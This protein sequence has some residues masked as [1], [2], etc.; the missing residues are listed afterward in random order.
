MLRGTLRRVPALAAVL[1]H[2]LFGASSAADDE[3]PRAAEPTPPR[4]PDAAAP[5]GTA[6]DERRE[7]EA[8]ETGF[9]KLPALAPPSALGGLL[10][11][12]IVRIEI[13]PVGGRWEEQPK[14]RF[15]RP[16]DSLTSEVARRAMLELT[17]TGRFANV[18]AEAES[19][20]QGV[21]LRIKVV[22]R[23]IVASVRVSGGVL[24][25]EDTLRTARVRAGSEVTAAELAAIARRVESHYARRGL[26]SA[27]VRI[28]AVDTDDPMRVVVLLDVIPGEP[29]RIAQRR[30]LIW[31]SPKVDGLK[32]ALSHYPVPEKARADEEELA[33]ADRVLEATMRM[34]GWHRAVV[35]HEL[36]VVGGATVLV[37]DI[38]AGPLVRLKFEGIR[39][40]DSSQIERTLELED[41]D[42]RSPST[43]A[44]RIRKFYVDRGFLD[45]EVSFRERGAESAPIHDLVF[46]VRENELIRI[47]GREYPCLTGSRSAQDVGSEVDSFLSEELPGSGILSSVDPRVVDRL[48]GPQGTTGA[49][50]VPFEP[51]PWMTFVPEVYERAIKHVQ[52]LYRSEGYLSAMVGPAQVLRRRCAPHSPP[53]RCIPVGPRRRPKTACA[54]DEIGLPLEEP[55]PDAALACVPD[56]KKGHAPTCTA[57]ASRETPRSSRSA[58]RIWRISTWVT[59]HRRWSSTRRVAGSSTPTPRRASPS[60]TWTRPWSCRRIARALA[61]CSPSASENR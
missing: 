5:N 42:D 54:H 40:F 33:A 2:L 9:G 60:P 12:S 26:P 45:V 17:D 20:G 51:N 18:S 11:K 37:V 7:R 1:G 56:P 50:P 14:L 49:R 31:P 61:R 53:G 10:G 58:W 19:E 15:V 29:R 34:R 3:R 52:D 55:P 57:C 22:P 44:E 8:E 16:G 25:T 47:A 24:D 23:R 32:A 21:L 36:R 59:L 48:L 13:V 39:R 46:K 4:T 28:D 6:P 27:A 43:L 35:T 30:F 38:K 41:N